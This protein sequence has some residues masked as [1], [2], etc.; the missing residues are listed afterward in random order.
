MSKL[1]SGVRYIHLVGIG[2]AG[3]SGLAEILH[4]Q[5]FQ[6]SGSDL[7]F[8]AV[9]EALSCLGIPVTQGHQEQWITPIDLVVQSTAIP[10]SNAE[11]IQ[12]RYQG[13]PVI[14]RG[15]LLAELMR[16]Q[17]GI[18]IAGTHGKTT[19]TGLLASI[20]LQYNDPTVLIGG[21]LN[22]IKGYARLGT[23][24]FIAE[25]DESDASLLFLEPQ[26]AVVTNIDTDHLETYGNNFSQL[27]QTFVQFLGS[28]SLDKDSNWAVLCQDD[29]ALAKLIPQLKH[30]TISYG[31][32]PEAQVR[33]VN[34]QPLGA[35]SQWTVL[36]TGL[37]ET[38]SRPLPI[39]L[40]LPGQ[41]NAL[42]AMAAIAVAS[43]LNIPDS[44]IQ[45]TLRDFSGI[46]RRFQIL[47]QLLLSK[48]RR[49]TIIDD[50]GHHP[51]EITET[52]QAIRVS[53]PN[54][55]VV[56]IFQPHRYSRMQN[57]QL[58]EEFA[59]A[60]SKADFLLI[61]PIYAASETPRASISSNILLRVLQKH[62]T[63]EVR[64]VDNQVDLTQQLSCSL[65]QGDI[66]LFQG[67]GDITQ[68]AHDFLN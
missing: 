9:T 61:L 43:L 16:H 68:M 42:N 44:V 46:R 26:I 35:Q 7:K 11:L 41:Y 31:F 67:A 39:H 50:Y 14:S 17:Y 38:T 1:L 6:V 54:Q 27:V 30:K 19:T 60:L 25:A 23:G 8:S 62:T 56:L 34:F 20:C 32:S 5:G 57:Q 21:Y 37:S 59:E 15:R 52:L 28:I 48:G 13:I 24:P 49:V 12:A 3:M 2:G 29:P 58:V 22:T 4:Y 64:L 63:I 47:G 66:V 65:E 18:A 33:G 45:D 53:W 55:R 10:E 51:V 36:R 40:N